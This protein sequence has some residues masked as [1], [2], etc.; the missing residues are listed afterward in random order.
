MGV[1]DAPPADGRLGDALGMEP[2]V[3]GV[4]I[5]RVEHLL[6]AFYFE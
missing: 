2:S 4:Y 3:L 1:G 6:S 5:R